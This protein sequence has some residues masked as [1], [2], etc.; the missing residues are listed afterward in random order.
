MF[1]IV[2]PQRTSVLPHPIG[3][4]GGDYAYRLHPNG[5]SGLSEIRSH[6]PSSS[7]TLHHHQRRRSHLQNPSQLVAPINFNSLSMQI[8][9]CW[10]V[11]G[12]KKM[13]GLSSSLM[14]R[15]FWDSVI[16]VLME[17]EFQLVNWLSTLPWPALNLIS[18]YPLS[19]TW[20]P[21][22]RSNNL[23]LIDNKKSIAIFLMSEPTFINVYEN[24]CSS[25]VI[26]FNLG[27]QI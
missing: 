21:I 17:W 27:V 15:G 6:L 7:R 5:R 22:T 24:I 18:V 8:F 4:C 1:V 10:F 26:S 12:L 19:W 9:T 16:L 3:A 13:S 14:A 23:L 11:V 25:F 2:G 20:E